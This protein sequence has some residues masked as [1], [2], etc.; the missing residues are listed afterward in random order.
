[1]PCVRARERAGELGEDRQMGVQLDPF[2]PTDA[3]RAE[4]PIVRD[5]RGRMWT[6]LTPPESLLGLAIRP[7]RR[8]SDRR[9]R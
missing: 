7:A 4:R 6:R 3:E 8:A 2:D 9:A 5:D 1:M